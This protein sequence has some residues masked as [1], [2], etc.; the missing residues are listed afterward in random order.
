MLSSYVNIVCVP[1]FLGE[2]SCASFEWYLQAVYPGLAVDAPDVRHKFDAHVHS[3]Y[4]ERALAPLLE[5]YAK[6]CR[7][8]TDGT[9]RMNDAAVNIH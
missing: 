9:A 4:V 1:R 8:D 5:Q 6:Q 7:A 2:D 3:P